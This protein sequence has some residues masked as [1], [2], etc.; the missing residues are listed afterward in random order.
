MKL[1][2]KRPLL[3]HVKALQSSAML[4]Q[5]NITDDQRWTCA[6]MVGVKD[7]SCNSKENLWVEE[8]DNMLLPKTPSP[9]K[10]QSGGVNKSVGK[11]SRGKKKSPTP[12]KEACGAR[13]VVPDTLADRCMTAPEEKRPKTVRSVMHARRLA[14]LAAY[15]HPTCNTCNI[16]LLCSG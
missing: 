9:C 3:V 11:A 16:E 1:S 8:E 4:L 13:P 10:L 6:D 14:T 12:S 7:A 15:W 2:V 5:K